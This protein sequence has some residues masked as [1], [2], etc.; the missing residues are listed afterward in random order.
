MWLVRGCRALALREEDPDSPSVCSQR[1]ADCSQ[2]ER[3]L[4]PSPQ[5]R[6]SSL[7][8]YPPH[9]LNRINHLHGKQLINYSFLCG[10]PLLQLK[11]GEIHSGNNPS[12][13]A[14][15]PLRALCTPSRQ[16][17]GDRVTVTC[18]RGS[19]WDT[20][21]VL[22]SGW[23]PGRRSQH[24][25]CTEPEITGRVHRGLD[26]LSRAQVSTLR[27]CRDVWLPWST[28]GLILLSVRLSPAR[29]SSALG[30]SQGLP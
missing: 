16:H 8:H 2:V 14:R 4:P 26:V 17:C 7:L 3:L 20:V 21:C 13:G 1:S 25:R 18:P 28:C 23:L 12:S 29:E 11:D 10:V 6:R 5:V 9:I 15:S 19:E 30:A 24:D 27:C 22:G